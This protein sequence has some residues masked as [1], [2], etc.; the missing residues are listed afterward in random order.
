MGDKE[1]LFSPA[2]LISSVNEGFF[3]TIEGETDAM[4]SPKIDFEV[5]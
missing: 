4:F 5:E 1:Y 3:L 2:T